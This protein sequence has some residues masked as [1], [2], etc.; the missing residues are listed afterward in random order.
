MGGAFIRSRREGDKIIDGGN[1]KK[2]KKLMC[3]KKVPLKV[4]NSL[5]ILCLDGEI[6]Y[7]PMCAICDNAK[8]D[9]EGEIQIFIYKK[10]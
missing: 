4:R 5:P 3:D 1:T 8:H 2:L 6:V 10:L 7:V 9:G